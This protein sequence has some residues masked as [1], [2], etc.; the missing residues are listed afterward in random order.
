MTAVKDKAGE[1]GIGVA[2][3]P[4]GPRITDDGARLDRRATTLRSSRE[5]GV[6]QNG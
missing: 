3:A 1:T 5:I 6:R 2:N 4:C